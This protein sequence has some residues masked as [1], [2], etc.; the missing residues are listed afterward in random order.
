[1]LQGSAWREGPRP[2][3]LLTLAALIMAALLLAGCGGGDDGGS[4]AAAT[5]EVS[6][7]TK[8]QFTK[9]AQAVCEK[10]TQAIAAVVNNAL[11]PGTEIDMKSIEAKTFPVIEAI[12][13]EVQ[14]LGAPEG[15]QTNVEAFLAALQ[16]DL[17]AAKRHPSTSMEA[18]AG[19]F[20]SSGDLAR[21]NDLELCAFG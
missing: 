11:R 9:R 18:L 13:R 19:Q 12:W 3:V 20:Q 14:A 5:V 17:E 15:D 21:R 6:S 16:E 2:A 4:S 10:R 1:M 7:L 8:A